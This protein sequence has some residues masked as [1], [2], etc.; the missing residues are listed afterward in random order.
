MVTN[1]LA[2]RQVGG[3]SPASRVVTR[4]PSPQVLTF[5]LG[6]PTSA[7]LQFGTDDKEIEVRR[8]EGGGA[9]PSPAR[10]DFVRWLSDGFG[11]NST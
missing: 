3:L 11:Q 10:V 4:Y 7:P 1:V 9:W 5:E 6:Q 2:A 8:V